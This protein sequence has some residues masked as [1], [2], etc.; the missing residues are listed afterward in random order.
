MVIYKTTNLI[1]GKWYIGQDSKNIPHYYG[2]GVLLKKAIKK[3]GKENFKKEILEQLSTNSTKEDLNKAEIKWINKLSAVNNG[4]SYNIALGGSD[5]SKNPETGKKISKKLIGN[6]NGVGKRPNNSGNLWKG[7]KG[8]EHHLFGKISAKKGLRISEDLRVKNAL[9][10]GAKEFFK[11]DK[12]GNKEK[13]LIINDCARKYNMHRSA[14]QQC[15][16]GKRK[17]HK[18]NTFSYVD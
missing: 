9:C 18:N 4:N 3:Y 5:I 11:I 17:S 6:K 1:N 15:L 16:I 13:F 14:I 10:H 7:K 2:G 8:S 12:Y